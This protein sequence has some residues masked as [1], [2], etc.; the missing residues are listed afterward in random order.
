MTS[1]SDFGIDASPILD[2]QLKVGVH[3]CFAV[4]SHTDSRGD[5]VDVARVG[6]VLSVTLPSDLSPPRRVA[7]ISPIRDVT[8]GGGFVF[9]AAR[10]AST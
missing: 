7:K 2:A 6:V 3:L 9:D 5:F 1:L 10:V 4:D 8:F